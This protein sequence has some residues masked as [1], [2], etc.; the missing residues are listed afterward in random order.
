MAT[1]TELAPGQ[2]ATQAGADKLRGELLSAHTVRCGNAWAA[3]ATVYS[4]GAAEIEV[5]VGY[6]PAGGSWRAH[7]YFYSF[8][9]ATRALRQY[10][11]TGVLPSE[12]D[13]I[14]S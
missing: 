10:E 2:V 8:E 11:A 7:D 6:D 12:S 1:T 13:L 9:L 4:D 14:E 5:S 3:S